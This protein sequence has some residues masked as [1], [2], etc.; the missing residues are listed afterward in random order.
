MTV[1]G[2]PNGSG[3]TTLT[4]MGR[5]AFQ[6]VVV[7][8]PDAIAK[9]MQRL[10]GGGSS[11]DAGR[12]VIEEAERLIAARQSLLVE[13]TLSGH[14]YLRMM[15]QAKAAGYKIIFL[16]VGTE[17]VSIN[18]RRVQARVAKGGHDIPAED[19]LRRY[20]RTM[21]NCRKAFALADEA[22]LFDNSGDSHRKVA[23]KDEHGTVLTQ[24][25]PTWAE[26][27]QDQQRP[28]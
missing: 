3:K 22:V 12:Y 4:R 20:P 14:T 1:V 19:Q 28:D 21:V 16:F 25:L 23:V 18:L 8:D 27:L 9:S 7:L 24:P 17:D 26:W 15:A 11:L 6:D 5:E 2:G 13:T 10:G